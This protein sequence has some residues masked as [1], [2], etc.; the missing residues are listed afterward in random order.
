MFLKY[1]NDDSDLS[2]S[3]YDFILFLFLLY[4]FN[5]IFEL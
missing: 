1:T 4:L 3:E 5:D 2:E